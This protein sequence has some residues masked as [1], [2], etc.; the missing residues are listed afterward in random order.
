MRSKEVEFLEGKGVPAFA[1]DIIR[2]VWDMYQKNT[3]TFLLWLGFMTMSFVVYCFL[4]S[5]D[6]SFLL[7]HLLIIKSS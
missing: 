7:V 2:G 5:G 4:S 6:F 3:Q 1:H